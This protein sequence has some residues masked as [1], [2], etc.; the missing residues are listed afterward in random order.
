[1]TEPTLAKSGTA[2]PHAAPPLASLP[3]PK[4]IAGRIPETEPY[5]AGINRASAAAWWGSLAVFT[6]LMWIWL[7]TY[8]LIS[9]DSS[10]QLPIMLWPALISSGMT[11]FLWYVAVSG[12]PHL[13]VNPYGIWIRARKRPVKAVFLPWETIGR[14]YVRRAGLADRALCVEPRDPRA[15]SGLGAFA[16]FDQKMQQWLTGAKLTASVKFADRPEQEII[17]AVSHFSAGR[18]WIG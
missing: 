18:V 3:P 12:G 9:T 1:M 7:I 17:G 4:L 13:A 16:A 8:T 2:W 6:T 5:V 14:I 11:F 15:A 10:N